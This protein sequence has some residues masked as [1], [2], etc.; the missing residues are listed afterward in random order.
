MLGGAPERSLIWKDPRGFWKK[1]RPDEIPNASGDYAEI[2]TTHP[3]VLYRNLQ[4][5]MADRGLPAGG[6]RD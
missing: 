1:A 3:P 2:K 4:R 6:P 5:T